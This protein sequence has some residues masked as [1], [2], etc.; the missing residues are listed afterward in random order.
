MGVPL[1]QQGLLVDG[2]V[3]FHLQT[4]LLKVEEAHNEVAT[5]R[6]SNGS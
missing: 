6:A 4:W 5:E 2:E 1:D 3:P